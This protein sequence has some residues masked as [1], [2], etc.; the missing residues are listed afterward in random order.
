MDSKLQVPASDYYKKL[1]ESDLN[2]L[3][4]SLTY[5]F[6]KVSYIKEKKVAR[7]RA[8]LR[9]IEACILTILVTCLAVLISQTFNGVGILGHRHMNPNIITWLLIGHIVGDYLL[10]TNWQAEN[11]QQSWRALTVHCLIYT[12][13]VYLASLFYGG[14][15][16]TSIGLIVFSHMIIDKGSLVRWWVTKV[17][18]AT[19]DSSGLMFM[20][21]QSFH[22]VVLG[23]SIWL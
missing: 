19:T 7:T 16:V 4:K 6:L 13:A 17:K 9:W 1:I 21:D 11:K 2:D 18:K 8:A 3:Y 22:L 23:L 10:Q 5:E 20:V 15:S 14:I 12:L